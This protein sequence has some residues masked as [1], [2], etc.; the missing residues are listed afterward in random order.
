[1]SDKS[2]RAGSGSPAEK[3]PARGPIK[4]LREIVQRRDLISEDPPPVEGTSAEPIGRGEDLGHVRKQRQW[5]GIGLFA[6]LVLIITAD[7]IGAA[8]LSGEEWERFSG[9][10][11][12]VRAW[13][14]FIVG[15]VVGF[16]FGRSQN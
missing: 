13:I 10:M 7:L 1:M 2:T 9:E 6:L 5:F 14:F 4:K 11:H 8:I 3:K 12:D 15:S 16:Y